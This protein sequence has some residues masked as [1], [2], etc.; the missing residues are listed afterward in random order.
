MST[1]PAWP[2]A[3][4][5]DA[6]HAA[7]SDRARAQLAAGWVRPEETP[8]DGQYADSPSP[9]SVA[10]AVGWTDDENPHEGDAVDE[11]SEAW[12]RGY[13]DAWDHS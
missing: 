13:F 9:R 10:L 11:L 5:F 8:L 4:Q 6:A 12:E 1:T 3:E 2:T 7:G